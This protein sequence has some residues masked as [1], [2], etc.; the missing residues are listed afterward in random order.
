MHDYIIFERAVALGN[1]EGEQMH[2]HLSV[3]AAE[4]QGEFLFPLNVRSR[5]SLRWCTK[6]SCKLVY[7]SMVI[8]GFCY[9]LLT[10]VY[11]GR[12]LHRDLNTV[13]S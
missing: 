7:Q 3:L 11:I 13:V 4:A 5:G 9:Q 2:P 6:E 12:V 1:G 8:I 10:I